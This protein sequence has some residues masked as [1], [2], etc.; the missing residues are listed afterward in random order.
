MHEKKKRKEEKRWRVRVI[1]K[2]GWE[3]EK[4]KGETGNGY[5]ERETGEESKRGLSIREGITHYRMMSIE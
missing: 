2:K 5:L 3:G 1:N 4:T